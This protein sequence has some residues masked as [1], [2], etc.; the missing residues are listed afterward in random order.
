MTNATADANAIQT[1]WPAGFP[2]HKSGFAGFAVR[3]VQADPD[4]VFAWIRRVDLHEQYYPAL[5]FVR[6]RGG[7]WPV[8]EQGSAFSMLLGGLFIPYVKLTKVDAT[9]RSLGWGSNTPLL[10]VCHAFTVKSV[11][12]G[13]TLI[14]SE[15]RL[16]GPLAKALKPV[17]AGQ[18]QKVQTEW[19][20]AL[21]RMVA[22]HPDG[23]P[24][25]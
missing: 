1:A 10:S 24:A 23:P 6:R 14:R 8:L 13:R 4:A 11:G 15:E 3:E 19:A 25:A 7:A 17:A 18:L 20:E 16:V 12:E 5:R 22:Q 2:A 21:V 9:E